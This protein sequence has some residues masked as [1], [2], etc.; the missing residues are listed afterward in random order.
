MKKT[1]KKAMER[2]GIS[3][4][5]F[6]KT[7]VGAAAGLAIAPMFGK[8]LAYGQ[9]KPIKVV[10]VTHM[11]GPGSAMGISCTGSLNLWKEEVNAKGGILGRK[12]EINIM[13]TRGKVEEAVR[14]SREIASSKEADVLF[15]S[16]SSA[17]AFSIKE[18]SRDLNFLTFATNSKTTELT[19]DPKTHAPFHFRVAA[20]N[21]SDMIAGAMYAGDLCKKN[22]WTKWATIG[23]DN[24][25][26][27]ENVTLFIYYLKKFYPEAEIVTQLWPKLWEPDVT[28]Y[29]SKMLGAKVQACFT[30]QWGGDITAMI[31]QGSLYG[32]YDK[33]KLFSIDLGD[34]TAIN[35]V[36]KALGKFP[37]GI[38][39][40]T[41]ANPTV[42]ATK[43]NQDWFAAYLKLNKHEPTGWSQQVYTG[44]KLYQTAIEKIGSTDQKAVRDA[45]EDLEIVGPWG[46]PPDSKLKM[47]RRDHTVIYYFQGWG[48]TISQSPYVTD[49][50]A[51]TWD[52]I[53]PA[54]QEYLKEKGWI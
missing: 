50:L 15:N 39:M 41:R 13:D 46:S 54:E 52:K 49:V 16:C 11:T 19:A 44:A 9:Q 1:G 29:I 53:L 6:L 47:R 21:I 31:Q 25:Y 42:P 26:G 23:A 30:T 17:E 38:Y 7:S 28:P 51:L 4:R 18:V 22:K 48:R 27:R 24:A 35:A 12:V 43:I 32:F 5:D 33:I 8:S 37:E 20:M 14:L 3:R 45:L 2:K 40:G 10:A 34:F 36:V